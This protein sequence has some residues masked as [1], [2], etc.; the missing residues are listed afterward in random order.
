MT[1]AE[2]L[3]KIAKRLAEIAKEMAV[4]PAP[5]N[6]CAVGEEKAIKGKQYKRGKEINLCEGCAFRFC[7][8]PG[9]GDSDKSIE[10]GGCDCMDSVWI[11][12]TP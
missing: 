4:Q 5:S 3:A 10:D 9:D 8:C 11:E 1:H 6:I 2:E 7:D 12:V